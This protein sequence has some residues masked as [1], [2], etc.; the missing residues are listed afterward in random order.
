MRIIISTFIIMCMI[1]IINAADAENIIAKAVIHDASDGVVGIASF[2]E[3]SQGVNISV[4]VTSLPPGIHGI[5]IHEKG[6]C[7]KPEFKSAGVHFNPFNKSHGLKN[8]AGYH[9]GDLGNLYVKED[10]TG[11]IN[12]ISYLATLSGGENSLLKSDGTSIV[13]HSGAD[14]LVTDP[15]GNAGSRIACGVIKKLK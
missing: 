8:T 2:V 11:K 3:S 4:Q 6:E 1:S 5:H 13:I 12:V 14:D 9:V 15:A 7:E 10:G